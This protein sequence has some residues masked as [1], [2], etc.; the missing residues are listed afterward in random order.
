MSQNSNDLLTNVTSNSH[1][2]IFT[3]EDDQTSLENRQRRVNSYLT[4]QTP[5]LN[6]MGANL[7]TKSNLKHLFNANEITDSIKKKASSTVSENSSFESAN[8]SSCSQKTNDMATSP[9]KFQTLSPALSLTPC[10]ELAKKKSSDETKKGILKTRWILNLL[11]LQ[12]FLFTE[13]IN[14]TNHCENLCEKSVEKIEFSYSEISERSARRSSVK[15]N[16]SSMTIQSTSSVTNITKENEESDD[17]IEL[18]EDF[19]KLINKNI[20][21]MVKKNFEKSKRMSM[22]STCSSLCSSSTTATRGSCSKQQGS[23]IVK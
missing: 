21:K 2:S 3:S 13:L 19:L 16:A 5:S 4:D 11:V 8:Y 1:K 12:Y 14:E 15:M 10:V 6:L 20:K 17:D 9:I 18:D 23:P 22:T 7:K